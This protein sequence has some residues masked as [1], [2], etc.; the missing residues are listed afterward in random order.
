MSIYQF[1]LTCS[2][3]KKKNEMYT[4]N[5]INDNWYEIK[6]INKNKHV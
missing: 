5:K 4:W 3:I 2:I 1:I 6:S